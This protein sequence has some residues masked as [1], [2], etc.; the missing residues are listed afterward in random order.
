MQNMWLKNVILIILASLLYTLAVPNEIYNYGNLFFGFITLVPLFYVIF[1]SSKTRQVMFYSGLFGL[2]S[3]SFIYFWLL[4]FEDF[5]IWTLSGVGFAHTLYFV[6][7]G[8]FIHTARKKGN[9]RPFIV[10]I[11]WISYE[12]LKSIGYLGFPWNLLAQSAGI[13]PFVQIADITGQWGISF[14]LVL[15][16]AMILETM[17]VRNKS[18]IKSWIFTALLFIGSISYGIYTNNTGIPWEKTLTVS[19][20][21]QNADSW[22]SGQEMNSIKKGQDLTRAELQKSKVTPDLIV[23]SENAFRY[24]YTETGLRYTMEPLGDPFTSFLSNVNVPLLVGSPY[25]LNRKTMDALNAVLLISPKGEIMQ[26]YGKNHPVPFAE[27][28]PFWNLNIVSSFFK[29]VVG[30]NNQGWSIG[31]PN[32]IFKIPLS[33]GTSLSFGTPICFEDSFPYIS[34]EFIKH[35]AD[36]LIN[37]SNDSWSKT[38]SGETQ[39]LAAARLRAIENRRVLIRSTNAGV[40]TIIDPWG[41]M[42][43]TLPLFKS[44]TFTA[45]IPVYKKENLTVYTK[46]GNWFPVSLIFILIIYLFYDVYIQKR[47]SIFQY[48]PTLNKPI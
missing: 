10:T 36:I 35:G 46:M 40:S 39:H 20:I 3:S 21:Q 38:I 14:I 11:I 13:A 33:E 42:N 27:N 16:N 26:Y 6:I 25:M 34:R 4:Y 48:T 1:T 2:I 29:N 44:D 5:S 17:L 41:K 22:I 8:M 43:Y 37:L 28:I 32:T 18:I 23:W 24:P 12:Y 31:K 47:R 7:L 45:T 30:I 15:L 9:L 19:V